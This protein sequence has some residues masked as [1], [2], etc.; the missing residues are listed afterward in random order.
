MKLHFKQKNRFY[1]SI[2]YLFGTHLK[3]FLLSIYKKQLIRHKALQNRNKLISFNN[4]CQRQY[5]PICCILLIEQKL[6][7][8]TNAKQY[9]SR[10]FHFPWRKCVRCIEHFPRYRQF[11]ATL[12]FSRSKSCTCSNVFRIVFAINTRTTPIKLTL[13]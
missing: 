4:P 11:K 1:C 5:K 6:T 10:S 7:C 8:R 3:N 12:D 13:D 2:G 9:F